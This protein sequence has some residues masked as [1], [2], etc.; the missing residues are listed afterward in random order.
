[1]PKGVSKVIVIS[2]KVWVSVLV[3]LLG[4]ALLAGVS[5]YTIPSTVNAADYEEPQ[6][7]A[8]TPEV[9]E[10]VEIP[11]DT[12]PPETIEVCTNVVMLGNQIG[13][14]ADN[15]KLSFSAPM[16][17][18]PQAAEDDLALHAELETV[19]M[20]KQRKIEGFV[21][22]VERWVYV[23]SPY[24]WRSD[25]ATGAWKMHWG[26]D[27]A[28]WYG[29]EILATRSGTVV[30]ARWC[31]GRGYYVIIDHGDGF[32]SEYFHLDWFTVWRGDKVEAGE[33]IGY[34]GTTGYSTG[35]H[36]HFGLL[37][38]GDYVNPAEYIDLSKH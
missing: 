12:T 3:C 28:G 23:S 30:E 13:S 25:P 2:K 35:V 11:E 14:A 8:Q 32:V 22:P 1:M 19:F 24:G 37:F 33:V 27:L 20:E 6:V 17:Q 7:L 21:Y 15:V 9:P 10:I 36:L 34:M 16:A 29:D 5:G 26:V 31:D 18:K 38:D 4:V